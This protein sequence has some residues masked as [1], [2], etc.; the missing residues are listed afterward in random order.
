MKWG[1]VHPAED[2]WDFEPADRLVAFA[3][4]HGMA[5]HGH[6]L[7]WH[8]QLPPWLDPGMTPRRMAGVLAGHIE[9]LVGRYRGRVTAWDVL[10]E[11]LADAGGLRRTAS[12]REV[13]PGYIAQ[14]FRLAHAADP[15][16]RLYYN[17][18]GAEGGGV[19]ADAVHALVLRLLDE[20]VPIHGVGLEMHLRATHPP[21]P[22][23]VTD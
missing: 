23:A 17:D 14:A 7:V 19:K 10:N 20:G 18:Y 11:A 16:A 15:D 22:G 8:R 4:A 6:A 5:V 21:E 3:E 13:G 2:R 12:L 9:T 1:P